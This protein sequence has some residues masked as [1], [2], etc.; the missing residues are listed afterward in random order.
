MSTE[1]LKGLSDLSMVTWVYTGDS[2][3]LTSVGWSAFGWS[4]NEL[5]QQKSCMIFLAGFILVFSN[6]LYIY[7]HAHIPHTHIPV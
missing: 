7:K 2:E 3:G 5:Q 6:I 4:S 1:E